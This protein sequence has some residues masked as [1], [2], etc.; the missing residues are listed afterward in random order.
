MFSKKGPSYFRA[1][2]GLI[3][4][5]GEHIR[6]IT[7]D[8]NDHV[9]LTVSAD[10]KTIA[11]VQRRDTYSL[12]LLPGLAVAKSGAAVQ[13]VEQVKE[14]VSIAWSA[15]GKLLVSDRKNVRRLNGDGGIEN[16]ILGDPNAWIVSFT[17]CGEHYLMLSWA[18]HGGSNRALIWRVNADGS[19][20]LQLSKGTFDNYPVCSAD[21]KWVYWVNGIGPPFLMRAPIE[22]GGEPEPVKPGDIP[23]MYGLGGFAISLDRKMLVFEADTYETGSLQ[24]PSNKLAYINLEPNSPSPA[25]IVAID[26]RIAI[27]G[28]STFNNNLTFTPDGKA[29]A[30]I[31][32]D[33]G[34][35]N[36]FVQ[37]L[38]VSGGHQITNFSSEN[39]SQFQWSPDGR[40]LAVARVQ[41]ISDVVLLRE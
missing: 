35:D 2:I 24:S 26:P 11:T 9:S 37:P 8:T 6:P 27:G 25:R 12:N 30:Y 7:R 38:D 5:R 41:Y 18:F 31:V 1:Q 4:H 22:G 40:S 23:G 13:A 29:V 3:S 14:P 32:R 20:P 21:G 33:K 36:I 15:N 10:G 34:V 39:I 19:N 17:A 16:T 28:G